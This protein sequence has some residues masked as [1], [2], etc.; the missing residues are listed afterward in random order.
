[1]TI[2]QAKTI[3]D[4][5]SIADEREILINWD[6]PTWSIVSALTEDHEY[7]WVKPGNQAE[8]LRMACR[9]AVKNCDPNYRGYTPFGDI[10]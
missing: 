1:M 4:L 3:D 8:F 7:D 2:Y 5:K 6:S 10:L 9:V